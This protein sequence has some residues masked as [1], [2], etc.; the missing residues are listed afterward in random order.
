MTERN[1]LLKIFGVE[2]Q[3]TLKTILEENEGD[4]NY[5]TPRQM[6][7]DVKSLVDML[8]GFVNNGDLDNALKAIKAMS[9]RIK[10][11]E[12]VAMD[13]KRMLD[14]NKKKD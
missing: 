5:K 9:I 1:D 14:K 3:A 7:Q 4:L 8:D 12:D 10:A 2:G 11:M 13:L 6:S